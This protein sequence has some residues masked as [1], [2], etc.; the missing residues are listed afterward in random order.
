MLFYYSIVKCSKYENVLKFW[1]DFIPLKKEFH[2]DKKK[3][4]SYVC[5]SLVIFK[6]FRQPFYC[7]FL[8]PVLLE[9]IKIRHVLIFKSLKIIRNFK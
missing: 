9:N 1:I 2:F 3:K 4:I 5:N 6:Y 7:T 8:K